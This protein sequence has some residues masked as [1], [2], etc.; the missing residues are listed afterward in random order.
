MEKIDRRVIRTRK[1][2]QKALLK[3]ILERGYESIRVQDITD[4]ANL[5]RATFY[6]HYK[7]KEALLLATLE[8]TSSELL[9]YIEKD[10]TAGGLPGFRALFHHA[11]DNPTFY[12]VVLNHVGGRQKI[13]KAMTDT[14]KTE[15]PDRLEFGEIPSE[16]V[17]NYIVGAVLQLLDWWLSTDM[18]YSIEKMETNLQAMLIQGI[19]ISDLTTNQT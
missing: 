1:L 7:D 12:K 2:L 17:A 3:L 9:E 15:I 10:S 5:G 18:Q 11:Q 6:V 8:S 14:V 16:Y 13:T 4:V 19:S